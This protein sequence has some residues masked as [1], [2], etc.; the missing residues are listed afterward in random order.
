MLTHLLAL[1]NC[2]WHFIAPSSCKLHHNTTNQPFYVSLPRHPTS[3]RTSSTGSM[4]AGRPPTFTTVWRM[5]RRLRPGPSV[6]TRKQVGHTDTALTHT[7]INTY[8]AVLPV[9][10]LFSTLYPELLFKRKTRPSS[11]ADMI[12]SM[13]SC[14]CIRVCIYVFVCE[15]WLCIVCVIRSGT[16]AG[17]PCGRN[18]KLW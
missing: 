13:S 6:W 9:T 15:A 18:Q 17:K 4:P 7:Y 11:L 16:V 1:T 12:L 3:R 8:I 14:V 10:K 2:H 5:A